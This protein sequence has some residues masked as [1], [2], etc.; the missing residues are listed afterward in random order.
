MRPASCQKELIL[1]RGAKVRSALQLGHLQPRPRRGFWQDGRRLCHVIGSDKFRI[2]GKPDS[3]GRTS[4][5]VGAVSSSIALR[6]VSY[7]DA[8][9]NN[10]RTSIFV[11]PIVCR[12]IC[13]VKL[14]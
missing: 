12:S 14:L 13:P 8:D 3:S 10:T 5:I 2:T 6:N 1:A 4:S 9:G 7:R 11:A